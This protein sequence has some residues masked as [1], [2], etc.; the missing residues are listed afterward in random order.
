MLV[1]MERYRV[2]ELDLMR[3]LDNEHKLLVDE[4]EKSKKAYDKSE[5]IAQVL[6]RQIK[7]KEMYEDKMK[8]ALDMGIYGK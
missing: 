5:Q 7:L 6:S 2:T 4:K 8:E 3:M 1:K